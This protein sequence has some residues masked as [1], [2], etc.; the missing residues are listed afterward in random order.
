MAYMNY[1][2]GIKEN[3]LIYFTGDR[4]YPDNEYFKHNQCLKGKKEIVSYNCC[5]FNLD[6]IIELNF[7][8][9]EK[10]FQ[11]MA[12]IISPEPNIDYDI[13]NRFEFCGFDL[14]LIVTLYDA[15]KVNNCINKI[16]G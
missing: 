6:G 8:N 15:E 12:I 10:G 4:F 14:L 13:D 1:P 2:F 11:I 3:E 9:I 7:D 16:M 5:I